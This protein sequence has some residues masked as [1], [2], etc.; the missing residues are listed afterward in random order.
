MDWTPHRPEKFNYEGQWIRNWFSNMI[1][2]PFLWDGINW[3]SVE[4]FYQAHKTTDYHAMVYVSK[5]EPRAAKKWGKNMKIRSDWNAIKYD[6]MLEG[7][8]V[9]F[10]IPE[11]RMRLLETKSEILIEWNN[12]NDKIW[13][14]SIKDN[15]GENL[16]GQALMQVRDELNDEIE[17][18]ETS[19]GKI[20]LSKRNTNIY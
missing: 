5:L 4:N 19:I 10:R 15:Q 11:W 13:G 1:E 8:R 20:L 16:L 14:V 9:K 3:R 12:W 18:R 6:V 7:L 2:S 17:L